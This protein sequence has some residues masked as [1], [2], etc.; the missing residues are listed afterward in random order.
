MLL[1]RIAA[2]RDDVARADW[3]HD[4]ATKIRWSSQSIEGRSQYPPKSEDTA[5]H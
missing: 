1:R 4:I 3:V 2:E 5:V